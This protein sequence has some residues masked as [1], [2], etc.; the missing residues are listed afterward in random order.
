MRI[1]LSNNKRL[2]KASIM[3]NSIHPDVAAALLGAQGIAST[4]ESAEA[5]ARFATLVLGKSAKAFAQLAFEDE[6]SGYT[7][8]LRKGAP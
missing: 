4:P 7:A 6:A 1:S 2:K 8:A 3:T 5:G